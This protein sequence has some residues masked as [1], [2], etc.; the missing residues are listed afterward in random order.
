MS[1]PP[2][3]LL[4]YVGAGLIGAVFVVLLIVAV[5][6]LR[7]EIGPP[8]RG[9][10]RRPAVTLHE[11]LSDQTVHLLRLHGRH[12]PDAVRLPAVLPCHQPVRHRYAPLYVRGK[13]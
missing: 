10:H 6:Q 13:R 12:R 4:A 8:A 3:Q 5:R 2:H 7:R 9:E 11:V 1:L